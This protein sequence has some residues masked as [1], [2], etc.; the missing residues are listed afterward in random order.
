MLRRY[1]LLFLMEVKPGHLGTLGE[2]QNFV[3]VSLA[4]VCSN[5]V[6]VKGHLGDTGGKSLK[7]LNMIFQVVT[8]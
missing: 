2:G 7:N 1:G 3:S 4:W 5:L 6:E 8:F